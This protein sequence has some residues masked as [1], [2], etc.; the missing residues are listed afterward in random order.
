MQ[1]CQSNIASLNLASK[2]FVDETEAFLKYAMKNRME[3][4]KC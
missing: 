2:E 3:I 4:E 1:E